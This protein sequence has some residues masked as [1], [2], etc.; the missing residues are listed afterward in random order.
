[1]DSQKF[2]YRNTWYRFLGYLAPLWLGALGVGTSLLQLELAENI[3][4]MLL[5]FALNTASMLTVALCMLAYIHKKSPHYFVM[6]EDDMLIVPRGGFIP[7]SRFIH[8]NDIIYEGVFAAGEKYKVVF[9]GG[10]VTLQ[11]RYL[12]SP[13]DW[14]KIVFSVKSELT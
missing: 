12:N 14:D 10:S 13:S 3:R 9:N 8:Y 4:G 1:M 11:K 5:F 6:I 7:D 2:A